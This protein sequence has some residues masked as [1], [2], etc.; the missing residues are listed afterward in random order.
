MFSHLILSCHRCFKTRLGAV[1]FGETTQG[2]WSASEKLRHIYEL[3]LLAVHFALKCF[4]SHIKGKHVRV[5]S[6]NSTAVCYL[7]AMGGTKSPSCNKLVQDIWTWC[8]QN[9]VWLSASHLPGALNV[10]ADQQS[11]QFNERT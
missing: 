5:K 4:K 9:K 8:M 1:C 2:L 7:N 11:P 3:E 10:E 6:D